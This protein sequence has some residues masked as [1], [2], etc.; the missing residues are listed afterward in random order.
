VTVI[1]DPQTE[2]PLDLLPLVNAL[3][4][5]LSDERVQRTAVR[6]RISTAYALERFIGLLSYTVDDVGCIPPMRRGLGRGK[7]PAWWARYH[8][9]VQESALRLLRD[10]P[11]RIAIA[12]RVAAESG[13]SRHEAIE[14]LQRLRLDLETKDGVAS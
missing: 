12:R 1:L 4:D 3:C 11:V 5:W 9:H 8:T 13:R 10:R 6:R 14:E 7:P 2:L